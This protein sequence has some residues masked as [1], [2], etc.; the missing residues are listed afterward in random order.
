MSEVQTQTR[1]TPRHV[2]T[3]TPRFLD[4]RIFRHQIGVAKL[5]PQTEL[6]TAEALNGESK[7]RVSPRGHHYFMHPL[8]QTA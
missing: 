8:Q 1:L 4:G 3:E 2:G 6:D 5:E 7:L